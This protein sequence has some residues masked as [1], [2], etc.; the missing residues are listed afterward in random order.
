MTKDKAAKFINMGDPQCSKLRGKPRDYSQWGALLKRAL[1]PTGDS[2]RHTAEEK[3]LLIL[4]GDI[5]NRGEGLAAWDAFFGQEYNAAKAAGI[6]ISDLKIATVPTG[7]EESIG[8]YAGRFI[9]PG[10]GPAW[11]EKEFFSFD[12]GCCHFIFLCSEYMGNRSPEAI[13][14]I[15]NWIRTD[16]RACTKSVVFAVMHHPIYS[17]GTSFDDDVHAAAM[18]EN[19]LRLLQNCGVDFILCGHQHVYA[20][21]KDPG[22]DPYI[23][24]IMGVS[25][26]K[27][28]DAWD[29]SNMAVVREYVSAGTVFEIS[30][31]TIG[32]KT[33]NS[34]GIVLDE[35]EQQ[36]RGPKESIEEI[37][38]TVC[39]DSDP[40]RPS[41]KEG[42][43][44]IVDDKTVHFTDKQLNQFALADIEYSVMRKGRLNYEM[45][46]GFRF[47]TLMEA[48]RIKAVDCRKILILT[49][50]KGHQKALQ[51][52][53]VLNARKYSPAKGEHHSAWSCCS[54]PALITK[55][56]GFYMLAIGQQDPNQYNGR[57]WME[58]IRQIELI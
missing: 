57:D 11:H 5:V 37:I 3:Q 50:S 26:T 48:A 22:S 7:S 24:Q 49:D 16:L 14:F 8:V 2:T 51:L 32:L 1:L 56:H 40:L 9:N 21:T 36:V 10:N 25:G 42:I 58:D 27:Y 6:E 4:G 39:V 29:K 53:H 33:I 23:T 13:R 17:L 54:V 52:D 19:Y 45:K 35:Y 38:G 30:G 18:R 46:R 28:F 12:W 55:E 31:E 20:R 34:D 43:S 47:S 15:S 44:L 41:N